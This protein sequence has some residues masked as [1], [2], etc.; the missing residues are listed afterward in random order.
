MSPDEIRDVV[1]REFP[2]LLIKQLETGWSFW[3]SPTDG[4]EGDRV[5][6]AKR[7]SPTA[8]TQVKFVM[9]NG[10][11]DEKSQYL[12]SGSEQEL[13]GLSQ[14]ALPSETPESANTLP[15]TPKEKPEGLHYLARLSYN[16]SGWKKPTSDAQ[17]NE[18]KGTYNQK[19]GFGH[20]DWLFR[21][22]WM[23]DGW[24]YG[25][26]QGV[27][28]SHKKLVSQ[29][30]PFDL[31]LFTIDELKRRRY[32]ARVLGAGCLDEKDARRALEEFKRRG[33]YDI[34]KKE[35]AEVGGDPEAIS[36]TGWAPNFLNVRFRQDNVRPFDP[37]KFATSGDPIQNLNRYTLTDL[38]PIERKQ[39]NRRPTRSGSINPPSQRPYMR[40][41]TPAVQVSPE[42]AEMQRIL[43]EQLKAEFPAAEIQC[44]ENFVDVTVLTD[45]EVILYE[46]K[47][48][49]D[50]RAVIRHALGQ[51]LEYAY[52]PNRSYSLPVRLVIVGRSKLGRNERVYLRRLKD[53]FSLLLEYR[54][55]DLT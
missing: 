6:R 45:T 36:D 33:W 50:S 3:L 53:E 39:T 7:P 55:V 13:I 18:V 10:E 35:V 15:V 41:A 27:N 2:D 51:I 52:H 21:D 25:F 34:M 47:S 43:V 49:L 28:R 44:E 8:G 16:T 5:F 29:N 46:L 19:F 40:G 48:D 24:R 26:V 31:T 23:I 14:A 54:R 4:E 20:E 38:D 17:G 42:H 37:G 30:R 32:V 1:A 11:R 9:V 22:E 12:F